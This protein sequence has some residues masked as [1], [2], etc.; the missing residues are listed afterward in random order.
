M[1]IIFLEQ[2]EIDFNELI[3]KS[4]LLNIYLTTVLV[5]QAQSYTFLWIDFTVHPLRLL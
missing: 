3:L 5:Y 4:N 2:V 1:P